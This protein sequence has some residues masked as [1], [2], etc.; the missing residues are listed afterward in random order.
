MLK[1]FT[2][3]IFT[4]YGLDEDDIKIY[5]VYLRVPR[6]TV[7]EVYFSFEEEDENAIEF[8]RVVEITN[9][10]VDK[11]F[12]KEVE[13]VVTRYIPLEPFFELFINESETFREEIADIKDRVL[14]DQ[15]NR[16][17]K[18]EGI[19]NQSIGKVENAVSSQINSFFEDS[20]VKNTNKENRINGAKE[21]FTNTEKN[22]ESNI[23][24]IMNSLNTDLKN[25]S[26]SFVQNNENEINQTKNNLKGIIS[27]LLDDFSN[28]IS[29]L[30]TEIKKDLDGHVER[31]KTTANEL[32]PKTE[33]IL[34]KYLDRMDKI[35][36]EL[37]DKIDTLLTRHIN[38]LKNTTDVLQEDLKA[39]FNKK[40]AEVDKQ[41][42]D[43]K[44]KTVQLIE[45]LLEISGR[46]TD[47]SDDLASRGSAFKA[48]LF[49]QHKKYK[50]RYAQVRED[51]LTYSKPLKE[52][53]VNESEGFITTDKSTTDEVKSELTEI[54]SNEN[55]K[56]S[57]ETTELN[58]EA[59][60]K[61]D[62][63]LENLASDL[64]V[65]IDD[66]FKSGIDDC[67]DTTIK[68]KDSV[69]KSF[70]E[71]HRKYDEAINRHQEGSLGHYTEFDKEIKLQNET[72]TKDVDYKFS[73]AKKN[74]SDKINGHIAEWDNE[75]KELNSNLG[76][77]L[78]DHKSKYKDN[79]TKLQN[80]LSDTTKA[81]TQNIKDAIADFTLEFMNS[82]DDATEKGEVNEEKVMDI[83]QA[84]KSIPEISK[85]T[86]WHTVGKHALISAIKDAVYRTK[87]SIIIVTP[88]PVPDVLQVISE[89]AFQKKAA[90]FM[91][92][93]N[94]D[95][96]QYGNI[97]G[98][99]KQLGNIQF[100]QLA[101]QGDYYAVTRDAE[102]VIICP[103]TDKETDMI[104]IISNQEA[105][106]KLYSSFIG[107]IFQANSRPIK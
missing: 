96:G 22:L 39:T 100:R 40:H 81:T 98:K 71:H 7:S 21:R 42:T 41:T 10:L 85:I 75:S 76:N 69:E 25:I 56:L 53:F 5:L 15:S 79:A 92:T 17:E 30:E 11:G 89:Y 65:E 12:L 64:T 38:H 52:D 57:G 82:I 2:K 35:V 83:F 48:L 86:T 97:I 105:Y 43:F 68:L 60:E 74:V 3:K 77:M 37:K 1:E 80:S 49:G 88:V 26:E 9:K 84:S 18:L 90:R 50:A 95:M 8:E 13:G 4:R 47:L 34:E 36:N 73:D 54:I 32:K 28:R 31:H 66:T 104:S 78:E 106:A 102:E 91:L 46:F 16:F 99:M 94:F 72:W 59:Q 93:S 103:F 33:M 61:V 101:Q 23:H 58:Q 20:D 14:T 63:Q 70:A 62:I 51:I 29:G 24:S 107:P 55:N 67:S 19:Q 45:N 27:D 44:N 6:A 87:S